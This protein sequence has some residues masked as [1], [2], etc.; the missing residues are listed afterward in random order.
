MEQATNS[1][2]RFVRAEKAKEEIGLAHDT[3][4]EHARR[5]NLIEG[6][7]FFRAGMHDGNA[8]YCWYVEPCRN[9]YKNR[10]MIARA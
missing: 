6:V 10:K 4:R 9:H 3:L 2:Q 7:H 5:G 8:K 1:G